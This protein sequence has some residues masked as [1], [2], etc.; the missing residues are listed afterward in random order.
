MEN[1]F[2]LCLEVIGSAMQ[3]RAKNSFV[4]LIVFL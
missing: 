2:L 4:L 1:I 3:T